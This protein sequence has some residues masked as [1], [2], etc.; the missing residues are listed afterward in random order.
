MKK[1]LIGFIFVPVIIFA[2]GAVIVLIVGKAPEIVEVAKPTT[3]YATDYYDF[4]GLTKDE[5]RANRIQAQAKKADFLVG[6]PAALIAKVDINFKPRQSGDTCKAKI[7]KFD[8]SLTYVYP[9]LTSLPNVSSGV[10]A[11]WNR[12]IAALKVHEEGHAKIE[13]ER[14]GIMLKELQNLPAYATCEE[15]NRAWRAKA[16][17]FEL[18]TEQIE[19]VYDRDT[20]SGK[21][22]GAIF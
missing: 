5:I 10:A 9:R 16:S 20:Q 12:Y 11:E 3:L 15:F 18:E 4:S 8:I 22:Q 1:I 13:V 6:H 17:A 19:A 7:T 14:A 21:T 2:V